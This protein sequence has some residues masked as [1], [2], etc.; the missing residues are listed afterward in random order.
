MQMSPE[1]ALEV[2]RRGT[3]EIF[4][5]EELLEKLRA[6]RREGRPL[7]VKLGIDPTASD[8]HLGHLIPVLKL[9]VFQDLGHQAVLIIGDYT[10]T[11][12]DPSGRNEARPPLSHEQVLANA[13]DYTR[14]I[15][16]ILDPKRTEVRWNG[17]WF[18]SMSFSEVLW[19]LSQM[20]VAR[21]LEREDFQ[22]RFKGQL[23]ISLHEMV[24]PLMQGYD[25]VMVRADVELGGIDQKFNIAVGR[26]L[27]RARGMAPQVGVCNPLLLGTDGHEK[28]SKSLGNTIPWDAPP[29]D[30]FGKLMSIPDHLIWPYL[31]LLTRVPMD[32]VR[33]WRAAVE[34]GSLHPKEAKK[35]LAREV[36]RML[37][38]EEAAQAAEA[39]FDQVFTRRE[40]PDEMPEVALSASEAPGGE[41]W[42]V[43][44]V[45]RAGLAASNSEARRLI[46]QGA[47]R[48]D[49]E[50][51]T[52]PGRNVTVRDGAVLQVGRRR[53]VR[54]RCQV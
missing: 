32:E 34:E 22:K 45:V 53:F 43:A 9:K 18:G 6:S 25:S 41:I 54:L 1:E 36:V 44:L 47:V 8:L 49:G 27:Q 48:L 14:R 38:G 31:E 35:R 37:H 30:K 42:P 24:Y 23:P 29:E 10:A 40:L 16:Q 7:R 46:T 19:L 21:M 39:H 20:T 2:I 5:E 15:F 33:A 28:M 4:P 17:E 12:G 51:V 11:V 3:E 50:T 13:R 26:D 52:D